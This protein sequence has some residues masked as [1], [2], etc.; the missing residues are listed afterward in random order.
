MP[1]INEIFW[2][3]QGEGLRSGVP[4]VF[5]RLAG[6]TLGCPY[7]DTRRAWERGRE[8]TVEDVVAAVAGLLR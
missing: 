7:C 4:S 1:R 2:S 3:A 6:C 8:R 5:V